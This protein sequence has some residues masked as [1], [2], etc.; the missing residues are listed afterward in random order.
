VQ[1]AALMQASRTG[2]AQAVARRVL[3]I[4]PSFTVNEFVRAHT[5]RAE[6]WDPM[7]D[8]LRRIGLPL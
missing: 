7:G 3:E 8:A 5:G 4:E 2:E 6:I 1:A